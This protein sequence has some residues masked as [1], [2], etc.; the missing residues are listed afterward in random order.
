[1]L[2]K[3]Q[4]VQLDH[5]SQIRLLSPRDLAEAIGVSES[6]VKRWADDKRIRATRTA[7]GHRRISVTEAIRFVRESR[8]SLVKPGILGLPAAPSPAS[9]ADTS[10]TTEQLYDYLADGASSQAR[11]LVVSLY[12]GGASVAEIID[13]PITGAMKELGRLWRHETRGIFVEHRAT[14]LCVQA[15]NQL[16]LMIAVDE[17]APIAVG[18]A[19]AGD[20]YTI[21]SLCA[22]L[23]LMAEGYQAVNLG[24]DTPFATL[25]NAADELAPRIVWLSLSSG[26]NNS[27]LSA[28]INR[29]TTHLHR[30]GTTL[31][32]GGRVRGTLALESSP[33][34]LVGGSMAELAA[35]ARGLLLAGH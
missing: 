27:E 25:E 3:D 18:G 16:R 1:M 15:L 9:L 19:P 31:V 33:N 20:P 5:N 23:V 10:D 6:S 13:G 28:S 29:L 8:T 22:A 21:P 32:V 7:G 24:A 11:G 2:N 17:T 14:D 12:L 4:N 35:F 26:S 30:R 34:L